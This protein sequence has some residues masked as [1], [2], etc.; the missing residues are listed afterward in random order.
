[1][2]PAAR[3]A[4]PAGEGGFV[5]LEYVLAVGLSMLVLVVMA[6]FI[7]FQYGRGVVRAAVDQ[8][9]R[10][11]SR[12]GSQ[13]GAR[14]STCEQAAQQVLDDLLGGGRGSMGRG[15]SIACS[16]AGGRLD[17]NARGR[18]ASWLRAVPDWSFTSTATA[19]VEPSP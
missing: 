12:A 19:V 5:T 3:Q 6:N 9:V 4:R 17:A 13:A 14:V 15:V 11:G 7:V 16:E 10:A 18:F 8:G 2:D 1:V